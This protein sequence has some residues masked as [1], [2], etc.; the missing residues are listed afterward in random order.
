MDISGYFRKYG[1][2]IDKRLDRFLPKAAWY[3]KVLYNAMRYAVFSGGKRVRPVLSLAASEACS[4][5]WSDA[6]MPACAVELVHAYTLV[7]DDLPAMDNAD[8]R[9]GRLSCHKRFGEANAILAGDAL[10]TLAFGLLAR[11]GD[12]ARQIRMIREL[13]T[14][15][16]APGT[17]AGQA[18]DIAAK[19]K[20]TGK[21]IIKYINYNKTAALIAASLKMG[22]AAGTDDEVKIR[23]IE[24]FGKNLGLAYQIVD[25]V[26]DSE[27]YARIL[28]KDRALEE[29][30][31][32]TK[33]ALAHLKPLGAKGG[34]L[35]EIAYLL[36][37]RT[38]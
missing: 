32:L 2:I 19:G 17:V 1:G 30:R 16:G 37:A 29:A 13:S 27:G 38:K 14:F 3:P 12:P 26:L 35:I 34:R 11:G 8:Y 18:V 4:G 20:K 23:A 31:V 15:I 7:H 24:G 5:A 28:G 6:I 21:D 36:L 9:R 10:L 33:R 25:D 22:A